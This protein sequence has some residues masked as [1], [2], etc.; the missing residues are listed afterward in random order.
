VGNRSQVMR[1]LT[2][3]F[4]RSCKKQRGRPKVADSTDA[5]LTGGQ[6]LLR[7]LVLRRLL[8]RELDAD[9]KNVGLLLPPTV[10][11]VVA[12][13]AI[14]LDRRVAVNLN[15][16]V[17]QDVIRSCIGQAGIRHVVTSRSVMNKLN[18]DL[19]VELIML[20]DLRD[21]VTIADKVAAAVATYVMPASLLTRVLGLHRVRDD[22]LLTIVFTSG[23]TGEPKGVMLTNAN[24]AS[25]VQA[26]EQVVRIMPTDVLVGILPFFHSF[27][28]TVTMWTV[29][30]L[31]VKGVYHYNPL[32]GRQVGKM[33]RKHGATILLATPTFLRSYLRR[34]DPEDLRSANIVITGA[35]RLPPEL[36]DAFEAKFGHRPAEGYGC[37]ELSPL[38]SVNIPSS[39]LEDASRISLKEG[40]VGRTIPGVLAK[41]VHLETGVEPGVNEP[42][43]LLIKGPNVMKGYLNR[44]DLTAEVIKDGWYVT[45]D[46]AMIDEDGFITITGRESRFSKIGGEMVP[47]IK[48]EETLARILGNFEEGLQAAVTAIPDAKKGERLIV[49]HTSLPRSPSELCQELAK[50]G[51]PNLF[52][53]SPDSF[54]K[55]DTLPVLG[56]GKLDLKQV[57]AIA[58]EKFARTGTAETEDEGC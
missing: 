13:A 39:R 43:M 17:S 20:E 21:R 24:V 33:C 23:S 28:Y 29:L 31:D 25:N 46:V 56:S 37:T 27:G 14:S 22:D 41:I 49:V 55:V 1:L 35:E 58:L 38:T 19:G 26:V 32:D 4:I 48:I 6:L 5:E 36:A 45:G 47:H 16:T 11:A 52:I 30:S 51:L 10:P 53:P 8:R 50:A 7:T 3:T 40:T 54:V 15:Y 2:A 12:N 18:Y 9:E 57:K 34:C 42:G 44:P